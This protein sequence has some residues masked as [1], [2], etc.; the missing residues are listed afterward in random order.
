MGVEEAAVDGDAVLLHARPGA[1]IGVHRG[2]GSLELV[3]EAVGFGCFVFAVFDGPAGGVFGTAFDPP[4]V[5]DGERRDAVERGLHAGGAGGFV[6]AARGVDPD[7]DTLGEK[8]AEFPIV[9]LDVVDLEAE[10]LSL[11]AAA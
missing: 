10:E 3:V 11:A 9:V 4:S 7:I 8:C 6:G 5:E 1:W 2:D